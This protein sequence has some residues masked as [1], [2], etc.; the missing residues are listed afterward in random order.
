[1]LQ[2]N[3]GLLGVLPFAENGDVN[4]DGVINSID[5]S[6]ILQF[7]AGLLDTLGPTPDT[8][9]PS[10]TPTVVATATPTP[11]HTATATPATATATATATPTPTPTANTGSVTIRKVELQNGVVIDANAAGWEMRVFAG[12]GC[13]GSPFITATTGT[14]GLKLGLSSGSYSVAETEQAGWQALSPTCQNFTLQAG[15]EIEIVFQNAV[16][17]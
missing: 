14:V 16:I 17:P 2:F 12:G 4:G 5:A 3:A 9:A 15:E 8:P 1:M 7:T 13:S 10:P 11:T 6:L